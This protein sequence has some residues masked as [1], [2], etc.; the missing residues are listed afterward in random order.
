MSVKLLT[1]SNGSVTLSPEDTG[2][3]VVL[4]VPAVAGE[5]D[6]INRAGNVLQVVEAT[7]ISNTTI[8]TTTPTDITCSVSITPTSAS[9]KI[10]IYAACQVFLGTSGRFA[11]SFLYKDSSNVGS[12]FEKLIFNNFG[13]G[14]VPVSLI[15]YETAGSTSARSYSIRG[16][17]NGQS[18]VWEKGVITVMEI[19][20]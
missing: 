12:A 2:S 14:T 20:A 8:S 1:P 6:R 4:T 7:Q 5:I 11:N 13:D 17:I 19:A 10:V 15:G 18:G 3:D 9:S 16:A